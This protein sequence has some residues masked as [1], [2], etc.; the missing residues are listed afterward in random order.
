MRYEIAVQEDVGEKV[1]TL[2]LKKCVDG[3]ELVS[4]VNEKRQYLL[5]L[6]KGGK[7]FLY[8]HINPEQ[9]YCLDDTDR[10]VID[11]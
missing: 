5:K 11:D 7:L 2:S 6:T 10:I 8:G 4:N 3:V 1:A 9:G